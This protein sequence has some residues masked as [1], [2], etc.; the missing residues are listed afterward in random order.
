MMLAAA[1]AFIP[2]W[3]K[4]A[5]AGLAG[6]ALLSYGSYIVGKREGRQDAAVAALELSVKTLRDR[7]EIDDQV[8]AADAA[9]LCADFGLS[10]S[11]KAECVRRL[12]EASTEPR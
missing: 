1:L 3:L 2:T 9:Q 11:D 8:T 6:A 7:N 5:V 12:V 4:L 10:D